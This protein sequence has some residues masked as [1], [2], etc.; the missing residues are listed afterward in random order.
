MSR[1]HLVVRLKQVSVFRRTKFIQSCYAGHN[2]EGTTYLLGVKLC[3]CL[4]GNFCRRAN[5]FL[6]GTTNPEHNLNILNVEKQVNNLCFR[7]CVHGPLGLTPFKYTV[8]VHRKS[9][10]QSFCLVM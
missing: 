6:K 4:I 1:G 8:S 5:R 9:F 10:M 2:T 3:D 7:P